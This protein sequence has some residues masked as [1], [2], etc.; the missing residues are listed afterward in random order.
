MCDRVYTFREKY[1]IVKWLQFTQ[2]FWRI[3]FLQTLTVIYSEMMAQKMTWRKTQQQLVL[4][5]SNYCIT[6]RT[7]F[8]H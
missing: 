4:Y 3:I 7:Y 5:F 2:S 6:T 1:R 8:S